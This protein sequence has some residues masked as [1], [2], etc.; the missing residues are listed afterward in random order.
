MLKFN[1]FLRIGLFSV[2]IL[3]AGIL[4]FPAQA[5]ASKAGIQT[6]SI[7]NGV[8]G[9]VSPDSL[10]IGETQVPM[11]SDATAEVEPEEFSKPKML[12][13]SSYTIKDGDTI[14]DLAKKFALN[15]GTLL[16]VN[17][18]KNDRALRLG[19]ILLIPNQDGII[20]KGK[21]NEKLDDIAKK[22]EKEGVSVAA[23]QS[24][25]EIFA[26]RLMEI[27]KIF[28]PGAKM[29][30][31]QLKEVTGDIFLWP[32]RGV[33]TDRYGYRSNPFGGVSREFHNGLDIS[34][35]HG[36]PVKAAMP[37]RVTSVVYDHPS[38]GN[39]VV[40][41]H[42]N[43]YRTLYAHMSAIKTQSGAYVNAGD[44]IGAVGSTGRSTGPHLHFTVY[45]NGVTV[46]PR[47]LLK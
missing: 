47:A 31:S 14:S 1:I 20:Y 21:R 19:Q 24:A 9:G 33:L 39:Y 17:E 37:G 44:Q 8:G 32:A 12:L 2:L 3:C 38:Y 13:Y 42:S 16:Q 4:L 22:Y 40:I 25:N 41:T 46:N 34:A 45:K 35:S 7:P 30:M 43:G 10:V 11:D 29:D 28:I 26:D 18:I 6:A 36:S 23:I 15:S 5:S 27:T